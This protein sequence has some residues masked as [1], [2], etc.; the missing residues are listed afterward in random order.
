L[1]GAAEA[2][3]EV[4]VTSSSRY[5]T[6]GLISKQKFVCEN[7]AIYISL[8]KL[9]F[10]GSDIYKFLIPCKKLKIVSQ[11]NN[12]KEQ[13]YSTW[14][15]CTLEGTLIHPMVYVKLKKKYYLIYYFFKLTL[16]STTEE[17][18]DRKVAA[19]V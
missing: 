1:K 7:E 15:T 14:C 4:T 5:P 2:E 16:V 3:Q 6:L 8:L 12:R 17:L 11:G 19:P 9:Y 10:T 18:F 13:W